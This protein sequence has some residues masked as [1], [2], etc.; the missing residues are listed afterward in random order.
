MRLPQV[1]INVSGV[2][3]DRVETTPGLVTAVAEAEA[4]LG[5]RGRVLLRSSGTEDL[6][7]VMVE[8]DSQ[9]QAAAVAERLAEVVR[10]ELSLT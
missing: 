2:D 3:K 1:L 8:A 7:R 6:V 10:T 4:E 9:E 5:G